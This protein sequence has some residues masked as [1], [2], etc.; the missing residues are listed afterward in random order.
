PV[1]LDTTFAELYAA[2]EQRRRHVFLPFFPSTE[3]DLS[4]SVPRVQKYMYHDTSVT[5]DTPADQRARYTEFARVKYLGLLAQRLGFT[6]GAMPLVIF[7]HPYS[8][9]NNIP[10]VRQTFSRLVQ[11]QRPELRFVDGPKDVK[12]E[13]DE[14]LAVAFPMDDLEGMPHAVEPEVH[15]ELL[16]KRGLALSGLCT[17]KATILDLAADG[18]WFAQQ[19]NMVACTA[20]DSAGTL[21]LK[22]YILARALPFV[23][24]LQQSV[25]GAGTWLVCAEEDRATVADAIPRLAAEYISKELD[26]AAPQLK[27]S[28]LIFTDMVPNI[29]ATLPLVMFVQRGGKAVFL[30]CTEQEMSSSGRWAGS[31]VTYS[32]QAA[33]RTRLQHTMEQIATFLWSRGYYGPAGADVLEDDEGKQWI[34]D[35][36]VRVPSGHVL[37]MLS[38]H[39]WVERK[40]DRAKLLPNMRPRVEREAFVKALKDDFE[41]GSAIIVGWV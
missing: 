25:S 27:P 20:S 34:V 10:S 16:S 5:H 6:V 13:E 36:N 38:R 31:T 3:I 19:E 39:F 11:S 24:K 37:A 17:P 8:S 41:S 18:T 26:E 22:A 23:I 30:G 12:L 9:E 32:A 21:D 14:I 15:Y 40:M 35:L 29:R 33:L 2:A 28:S 4:P 7:N 1:V